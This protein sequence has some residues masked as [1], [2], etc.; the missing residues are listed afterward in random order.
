VFVH[1]IHLQSARELRREGR[2]APRPRLEPNC[3]IGVFAGEVPLD[4]MFLPLSSARAAPFRA[5]REI[6]YEIG[7]QIA[8]LPHGGL[9][10]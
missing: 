6:Y 9:R 2:S 5:V 10:G 8:H 4:R 7:S 1:D 3:Y